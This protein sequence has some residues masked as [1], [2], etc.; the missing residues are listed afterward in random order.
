MSFDSNPYTSTASEFSGQPEVAIGGTQAD[1]LPRLLAFIIDAIIVSVVSIPVY[2]VLALILGSIL[3]AI[4]LGIVFNIVAFG[5]F[6]AINGNLLANQGQTFGKKIMNVRIVNQDGTKAAFNDILVKRY[7]VT[8][9]IGLIPYLG[10]IYGLINAL[11]IFRSNHRC[12]HD[13]IAKTKV[14]KV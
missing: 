4:V 11:M 1:R 14:V 7:G 6:F 2:F 13:D 9:L 5:L 8:W 12:L 3:P 10:G